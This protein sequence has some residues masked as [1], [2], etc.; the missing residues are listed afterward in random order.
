MFLYVEQ[1]VNLAQ[2]SCSGHENLKI[3]EKNVKNPGKSCLALRKEWV[4]NNMI[5]EVCY[6]LKEGLYE[7]AGL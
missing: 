4:K 7:E 3:S 1:Y 2:Q 5:L 6:I